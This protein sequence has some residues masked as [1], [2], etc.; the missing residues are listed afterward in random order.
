MSPQQKAQLAARLARI[1]AERMSNTAPVSNKGLTPQVDPYAR[2]VLV[3]VPASTPQDME[4][5]AAQLG[6]VEKGAFDKT[7]Y[8]R[9]YMRKRRAAAKAG[10]S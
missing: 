9:E 3:G 8:Q 10:K 6:R 4:M 5:Q 2:Q 1:E 7:A